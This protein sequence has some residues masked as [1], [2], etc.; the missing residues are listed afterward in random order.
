MGSAPA[1][2]LSTARSSLRKLTSGGGAKEDAAAGAAPG[3]PV[4]YYYPGNASLSPHVVLR[5]LGVPFE[6]RLVDRESNAQKDPAYLR[7]N[8]N[9]YIP[10]LTDGELVLFES[11]AIVMHLADK[12][13]KAA[14][15]PPVGSDA[16]AHAVKWLF[17]LIPLQS[18]L[19]LYFYPEKYHSDEAAKAELERVAQTKAAEMLKLLDAQLGQGPWLIGAQY[20]VVDS[21]AWMLCRW[22]R[23]FE[24]TPAYGAAAGQL[25]HLRAWMTR[26]NERA[27]VKATLEAE[28]SKPY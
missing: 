5:E 10:A 4:L 20:T 24:G 2:V 19:M 22:T 13:P 7:I 9:G 17:W 23:S 25:P 11:A 16:R 26:M 27:A 14:L 12:Y 15:L 28:G 8:P 18:A 3:K 6:L 1:A 21:F